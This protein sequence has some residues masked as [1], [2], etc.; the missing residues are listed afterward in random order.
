[1]VNVDDDDDES[2]SDAGTDGAGC[3]S[4]ARFH[5]YVSAVI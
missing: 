4:W 3:S 1:M 5:E 2:A